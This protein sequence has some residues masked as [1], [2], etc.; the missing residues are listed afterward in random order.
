MVDVNVGVVLPAAGSGERMS[1]GASLPK[2]YIKILKKPLFLYAV[3]AFLALD[4][5]KKIVLVADNVGRMSTCLLDAGLGEDDR[6]LVTGGDTTR[7]RSIRKG[8]QELQ[9]FRDEFDLK[10]AIVHDAVR[11]F[12]PKAL[13][14]EL[15]A[16]SAG[17]GAAGPVRPLVS[18]VVRPDADSFL[19]GSLKRQLYA[20]SET[21]QAFSLDILSSAYSQISE[22]ELDEG[23][24]CLQLVQN[25]CGVRAKLIPTEQNLAKV[26]YHQDVFAVEAVLREKTTDVCV[27]SEKETDVLRLLVDS[28]AGRVSSLK[29]ILGSPSE[30]AKENG[31]TYN[32]VVLLHHKEI[33]PDLHLLDFANLID[34]DR[35][36]LI[37]HI[38]DHAS[39]DGLQ[40]MSVYNL[41]RNSRKMAHHYE[42]LHKGVVVI[43]CVSSN[44]VQKII[45]IVSAL[46]LEDPHTFSGQTLFL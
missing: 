9:K 7:H 34:L 22:E 17:A 23:T 44:E 42:K 27:I 38:I 29:T 24:E 1:S 37:V 32:T 10:V 2:Q 31:K 40:S 45:S 39:V 11:P 16:E 15:V 25:Y 26:T 36:G 3:E 20:N 46:T 8:L 21:P 33:Q 19:E 35:R 4:Y 14:D 41:H 28:L 6:I 13:V 12:V 43:H 30:K 5:V 18:T